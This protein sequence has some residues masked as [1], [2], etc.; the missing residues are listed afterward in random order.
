MTCKSCLGEVR[1]NDRKIKYVKRK[2]ETLKGEQQI[3]LDYKGQN[4][5]CFLR[6]Y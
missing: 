5:M 3:Y 4:V 6:G 1:K 2:G